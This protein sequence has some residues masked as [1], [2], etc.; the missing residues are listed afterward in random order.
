MPSTDRQTKNQKNRG[1]PATL[2]CITEIVLIWAKWGL[3]TKT[4]YRVKWS[5]CQLRKAQNIMQFL[6]LIYPVPFSSWEC[7]VVSC[8]LLINTKTTWQYMHKF[9]CDISGWIKTST[10]H[11]IQTASF[12]QNLQTDDSR[13]FF[14][15]WM[16]AYL[17]QSYFPYLSYRHEFLQSQTRPKQ[18][19]WLSKDNSKFIPA[20]QKLFSNLQ[21]IITGVEQ[22]HLKYYLLHFIYSL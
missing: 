18:K 12:M 15:T 21:E 5:F 20:R 16:C 10:K 4:H 19:Y 6:N 1:C 11:Q 14:G 17:R 22:H 8:S 7:D 3:G 9:S 2:F 13:I